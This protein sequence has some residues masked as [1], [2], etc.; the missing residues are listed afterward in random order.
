MRCRALTTFLLVPL[1]ATLFIA[2]ASAL[3]I[4]SVAPAE[5]VPGTIVT[6]TG[7][8]LGEDVRVLLGER[9]ITPD[10]IRE[11]QLFF[12]VPQLP[13]GEYALSL[14]SGATVAPQTFILR[15]V[16]PPPRINS[17]SPGNIDICSTPSERRVTV[18]GSNFQPG[19]S[20]LLD[21]KAIPHSR[22]S[23]NTITFT[24]PVLE[25]GVYGVQVVNPDDRSSLPHSIYFNDIPEILAV[26]Q[27]DEFV[28]NY[29]LIIEGKNFYFTSALVV[30]E[31]SGDFSEQPP[32]QRVV[33]GRTESGSGCGRL[34][35]RTQS[36]SVR[37][38]DCNTLIYKR[39]P[40]SQQAGEISLQII[41]PD[42]KESSPF[43]ITAP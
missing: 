23:G 21:G 8:A 19:A 17:V 13:E 29:Q 43:F 40:S 12:T 24:L 35:G 31:S 3:E 32:D 16:N 30:T 39:F 4:T 42:G 7:S 27:G 2:P 33:I 34:P 14:R 15:I 20:L 36:E 5:A 9:R 38:V 1:L 41:N 11:N 6:V 10:G 28:N 25:A 22:D 37:Y 26:R 18:S